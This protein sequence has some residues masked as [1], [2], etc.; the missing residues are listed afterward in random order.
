MLNMVLRGSVLVVVF[1]V[2]GLTAHANESAN[3]SNQADL[4]SALASTTISTI[5]FASDI[6]T[7]SQILINREVIIDGNAHKLLPTFTGNSGAGIYS[8][9]QINNSSNVIIKNLT[10]DGV[11]STGIHGVQA[12]VSTNILLENVT[13]QNNRKSGLTVNGSTVIAKKISTRGNSWGGINVDQGNGVTSPASLTIQGKSEHS[14]IGPDIWKDDNNKTNVSVNGTEEDYGSATYTHDGGITGTTYKLK[15]T[16]VRNSSELASAIAN[17]IVNNIVF[18]Q[19]IAVNS[20]VLINRILTLD[21]SG[22][23]LSTTAVGGSVINITHEGVTIKN[24]IENGNGIA[25]NNRGINVYVASG[26][27][28]ENVTVSNNKKNGIVVNGSNVTVKN[29]TTM[30]NGWGGI[31]VDLGSGVTSP[32]SLTVNGDSSHTEL[33]AIMI[34]DTRKAVSVIDTKHQYSHKDIGF[35]RVF[36]LLKDDETTPDDNGKAKVTDEDKNVIVASSTQP[37]E[38]EAGEIKDAKINFHSLVTGGTGTIPKTTVSS[39]VL[40]VEIPSTKITSTDLNWDGI[41]NLPKNIPTTVQPA[42]DSGNT[43]SAVNST[44]VG[45]GETP[46]SFDNP[47]KLTF[48]GQKG[49]SIGWSQK[50]VFHVITNACDSQTTPNL[51]ANSECKFEVGSD[52]VVWTKHFTTF[53]TYTQTQIPAVI[54]SGGGSV[55]SHYTAPV[56]TEEIK[57]INKKVGQ[58]LGASDVSPDVQAQ[59]NVIKQKIISLIQQLI[60]QLQAELKAQ[61]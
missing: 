54:S 2:A 48:R 56:P 51:N 20:E 23:T 19:D 11:G 18:G 21:G 43:V 32:A 44:E 42:P 34:D 9:I 49:S 17:S 27:T 6:S 7:N 39:N 5:N 13:V 47:V 60:I 57:V 12:Y 15:T 28:L 14:E 24:L 40:N 58:V 30:N 31:D 35:T 25:G 45:S 50:G 36:T 26:V 38:I 55:S 59:I 46:I 61:Q 53:T 3:V 29:I 4:E 10:E 22:Y 8:A 37:I 1:L 52:L 33:K 41:I 16:I